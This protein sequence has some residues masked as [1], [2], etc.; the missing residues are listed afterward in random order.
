MLGALASFCL[1][2]IGAKELSGE[3]NTFQ[4]LFVRS[5]ISLGVV[6]AII[7]V[8]GKTDLFRTQ[9]LKWHSFRNISHLAGQYGWFVA[10]GLLPLAE[11]FALEF[12]V[13]F[14]TA[15]LAY[16]VLKESLTA[17]KLIAIMCGFLGVLII[18]Q[19]GFKQIDF[20]VIVILLAAI[21][22]SFTYISTRTLASTDAPLTILFYMCI[23]QFPITLVFA[24]PHWESPN[25][26]Q[27]LWMA[28][29]GITAMSAH[30]CL[31]NAM[32]YADAAIVVTMD[33]LRLPAIAIV[34]A[35]FYA[36]KIEVT[37]LIGALLML[38]G[39]IV[40][41]YQPKRKRVTSDPQES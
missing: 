16:V 31:S 7:A 34:G 6:V 5:A 37:L 29:I 9:R 19:P 35:L 28:A 39:N 26:N 8:S 27:W 20:G 13:P 33:F 15:I 18:V 40:N 11:V 41:L 36:E 32:K 24:L 2:A 10:I 25:S 38:G 21:C 17:R 4:V 12:T 3:L 23:I 22:Y 1:M 30:Y 14:W